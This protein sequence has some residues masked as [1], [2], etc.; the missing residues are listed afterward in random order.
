VET[1]NNELWQVYGLNREPLP[2][3]T[4]VILGFGPGDMAKFD[5]ITEAAAK[6]G[7]L[8]PK[9]D[10]NFDPDLDKSKAMNAAE[11]PG[12]I[13]MNSK[14]LSLNVK[15]DGSTPMLSDF[16]MAMIDLKGLTPRIIRITPFHLSD[17]LQGKAK[18]E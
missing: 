11:A 4:E 7:S 15:R 10:L 18:P 1:L 12:G 5:E 3:G 14:Q 6:N 13:D 16:D 8:M 9:D 17:V 2:A